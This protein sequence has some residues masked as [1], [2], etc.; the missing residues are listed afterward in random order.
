MEKSSIRILAWLQV[1]MT[2]TEFMD[3]L[4]AVFTLMRKYSGE[5]SIHFVCMDWRH[6]LEIETAARQAGYETKNVCIWVKDNGGMGSFYRSRREMVFVYKS[7][8]CPHT[9]NIELGK[10]STPIIES[11]I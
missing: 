8:E 10:W 6:V 7:G 9:N 4:S 1:K 2:T 3:F 11:M 5:G